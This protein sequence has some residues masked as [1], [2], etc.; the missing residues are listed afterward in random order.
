MLAY[1]LQTPHRDPTGCFGL[2]TAIQGEDRTLQDGRRGRSKGSLYWFG[3]G[4]L[5]FWIDAVRGVV[6]VLAGNFFPF[7]EAGW[8][9]FMEGVEGLVY[10]GLEG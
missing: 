3:V 10:E 4:N 8:L 9:E 2:G 7:M 1:D 6:V 5:A